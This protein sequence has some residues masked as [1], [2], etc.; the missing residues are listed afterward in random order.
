[1]WFFLIVIIESM[2]YKTYSEMEVFV[3]IFDNFLMKFVFQACNFG[4]IIFL[5][6]FDVSCFDLDNL[7]KI[8]CETNQNF[9]KSQAK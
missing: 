8:C 2:V 5:V 9:T 4:K 6:L 3:H 1:M 7:L